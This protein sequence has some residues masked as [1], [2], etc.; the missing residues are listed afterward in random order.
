[1]GMKSLTKIH[2]SANGI[3]RVAG[4]M[5]GSGS[6]LK[7]IL[8]HQT[9]LEKTHGESP[10]RV[11]V[12]FSDCEDSCAAS[13]GKAHN[14]PIIIRSIAE[15]Y[16]S[17]KQPRRNLEIR[18]EYDMATV[19][20]MLRFEVKCVVYA[21]YMS[22]A[23]KPLLDAFLGIN[24]H[25]ADL[26]VLNAD[27]SRKYV[28]AHAVRDAILAGEKSL[29]STIH[30]VEPVVDGGKILMI[31]PPV[32]VQIPENCDIKKQIKQIVAENQNRLKEQ[33]DWQVFPK[34]VQYVAEG[35]FAQDKIGNLYFDKKPMQCG[36]RE[37]HKIGQKYA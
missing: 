19:Q 2:D 1:M 31:S 33:G 5:S 8:E 24:V 9:R 23:T 16:K 10:Y 20:A 37:Y 12:I 26:S 3:L 4:F 21:G 17:K 29:H 15:F 7:K 18:Q 30:I 11:V 35:R 22:I 6:N 32:D 14:I 13:I 36:V 27:G 25:P 28:G 34:T